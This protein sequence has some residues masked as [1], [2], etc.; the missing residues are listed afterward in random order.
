ML[1]LKF[2][3]CFISITFL[4]FFTLLTAVSSSLLPFSC[5]LQAV[6]GGKGPLL[7]VGLQAAQMHHPGGQLQHEPVEAE[8]HCLSGKSNVS[9]AFTVKKKKKQLT[10]VL[11]APWWCHL[12]HAQ[13]LHHPWL[14][15]SQCVLYK[16]RQDVGIEKEDRKV[17][18][19]DVELGR[20]QWDQVDWIW[21]KV[22]CGECLP[23]LIPLKKLSPHSTEIR[24]LCKPQ[25]KIEF[26]YFCKWNV[27]IDNNLMKRLNT[28][29]GETR[30]ILIWKWLSLF[31][32]P[33]PP[34]HTQSYY[35][36]LLPVHLFACGIFQT[37]VFSVI[38]NFNFSA[39]CNFT[40]K[41]Y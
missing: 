15:A 25:I 30:F 19:T 14:T 41:W 6:L 22:S 9:A 27:L 1:L 31:K 32:T 26:N 38:S 35:T 28:Q 17:N 11:M 10:P 12:S 36:H 39:F 24:L 34:F 21:S 3:E 37:G 13:W 33:P 18:E 29:S 5:P 4:T 2:R 16:R 20:L 23:P 7:W 40:A 8:H